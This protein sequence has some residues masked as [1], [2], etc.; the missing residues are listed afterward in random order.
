MNR[1]TMI[2]HGYLHQID[3]KKE[4]YFKQVGPLML[5]W[6]FD[7]PIIEI[8]VLEVTHEG[9]RPFCTITGAYI[10]KPVD[11]WEDTILEMYKVLKGFEN[12]T[13]RNSA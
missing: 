6:Y 5:F 13:E 9:N 8:V 10:S 7:G 11:M 1:E 12:E 3:G 2:S 4:R